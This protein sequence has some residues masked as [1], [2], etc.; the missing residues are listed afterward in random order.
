[1]TRKAT[2]KGFHLIDL[3]NL[4]ELRHV[5]EPVKDTEAIIAYVSDTS[6]VVNELWKHCTERLNICGKNSHIL[7]Y[8]L[9]KLSNFP[10]VREK[11]LQPQ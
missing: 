5:R 11:L 1:M 2:Y 4:Y 9:E 7:T 6:R 3:G 10:E 8:E